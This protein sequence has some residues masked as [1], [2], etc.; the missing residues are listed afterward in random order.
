MEVACH[1]SSM[2]WKYG[3]MEVAHH[4]QVKPASNT[5]PAVTVTETSQVCVVVGYSV[6]F[7]SAYQ[8]CHLWLKLPR[9]CMPV[10]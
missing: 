6:L 5:S 2:S 10:L 4:I 8:M 9:P 3:S 1:G 7:M